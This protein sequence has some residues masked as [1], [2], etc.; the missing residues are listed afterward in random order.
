MFAIT[1]IICLSNMVPCYIDVACTLDLMKCY[2]DNFRALHMLANPRDIHKLLT[3][4][5]LTDLI[6]GNPE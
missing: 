6:H 2:L 1:A 3:H 4:H 5:E